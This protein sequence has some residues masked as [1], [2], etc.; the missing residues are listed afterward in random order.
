MSGQYKIGV[1]IG[2]TFTDLVL[3][4]ADG[5]V[6]T[7]KVLSTPSDYSRGIAEGVSALFEM[8]DVNPKA[9]HEI[10]HG[11]TI[12]T[13][14]IIEQ[15]GARVALVTTK[16]FRDVL[17]LGRFRVPRLY[18]LSW[19]KP[20]A[21][22][23]RSRRFE[24]SERMTASG[25]ALRPVDEAE[26]DGLVSALR[27]S[28][29]ES[30]AI[31]FLNSYVN[32]AHEKIVLERLRRDLPEISVCASHEL[33]PQIQEYERT[34]TA[35][36]NAYIKPVIAAYLAS[37]E[38]R[39][40]ELGVDAPLR[41][42][43]SAGT[44]LPAAEAARMPCAIIESG[45][46]AGV[47]GGK[48]VS[49]ACG[50][51][52]L[53]VFDMGGTTAKA[54]LVEDGRIFLTCET[55]VGGGAGLATRIIRGAGHIVQMPTVDMAE[56][57][58]GG[59]S[60]GWIDGGGALRVGPESAGADPGP[61]C[62]DNG[63]KDATVTDANLILGYLNPQYLCGGELP[64]KAQ[65]GR[66]AVAALGENLGFGIETTAYAIHRLAI[67]NMLNAIKS[68]T[69]ERGRDAADFAMLA[70]GGNGGIHAIPLARE[71][72]CRQVIVPASSGVFSAVG[73]TFIDV[74]HEA[75]ESLYAPVNELTCNALKPLLE[76]LHSRVI[77]ELE[78]HGSS[79]ETAVVKFQAEMRYATQME[80]LSVSLPTDSVE[81]DD[82]FLRRHLTA[83]FNEEHQ[84][85]FGYSSENE[86]IQFVSV[87][88]VAQAKDAASSPSALKPAAS[89]S[90]TASG[91]RAVLF[92][93][94]SDPV[95]APVIPRGALTEQPRKGP[96][97]VDEYDCTVIVHPGWTARLDGWNSIVLEQE[98][99]GRND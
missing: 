95:P 94:D 15:K 57:G 81:K 9:I 24:L 86:A 54:S 3:I 85:N 82:A 32:A 87:R 27:R 12:A 22:A 44:L 10:A 16:G 28:G 21:L 59:G 68:V 6:C 92:D 60:I 71:L 88:G 11:T 18:D 63:G 39:L 50:Y 33:Q 49:S 43:T 2:G 55:E 76:V 48:A 65:L 93:M 78:A 89:I 96:L 56:V 61:A 77:D 29:A 46:A 84:N 42:V 67:A 53:I 70:I 8:H 17:E 69:V 80:T 40:A 58:A 38:H 99:G 5:S 72:G 14:T 19:R 51:D 35:V 34:S 47:C 91:E 98:V 30:V 41:I 4:G 90:A 79:S 83:L 31:C 13:N 36:V 62:Y 37:L 75:I 73:M 25:E 7:K 20:D 1:D 97:I 23:P 64:I 26:L 45:P 52:N 66:D 74:Q